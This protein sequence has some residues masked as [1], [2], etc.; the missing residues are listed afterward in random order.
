MKNLLFFIFLCFSKTLFSQCPSAG[1]DT[2][3]YVCRNEIFDISSFLSNEADTGG[4]FLN[5]WGNIITNT[6][7]SLNI[8]GIYTFRYL[9]AAD[10]CENDTAKIIVYVIDCPW[11]DGINENFI[12]ETNLAS[13]NPVKDVLTINDNHFDHLQ[14]FNSLGQRV[15]E[16]EVLFSE[17][18]DL[19]TIQN[20]LY[21]LRIERENK[22]YYQRILKE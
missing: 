4:V 7:I 16:C 20:G 19:S 21:L 15:F 11:T 14:L 5:P 17:E 6:S 3:I 22:V 12:E 9:V 18:I 10:S 8:S 2:N 1:A 13:P